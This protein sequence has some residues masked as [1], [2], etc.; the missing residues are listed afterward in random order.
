MT[1]FNFA[2]LSQFATELVERLDNL[3]YEDTR[4]DGDN[5]GLWFDYCQS[6][7]DSAR[8]AGLI[9]DDE[10]CQIEFELGF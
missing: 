5:I 3:L 8:D 10:Y 7:M 9:S 4:Y 6:E 1:E 2:T